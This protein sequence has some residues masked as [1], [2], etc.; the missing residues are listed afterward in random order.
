MHQI[1]AELCPFESFLQTFHSIL[2]RGNSVQI[3][4]YK[5]Y[6]FL[7]ITKVMAIRASYFFFFFFVLHLFLLDLQGNVAIIKLL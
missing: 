3:L 5:R 2:F 1:L 6:I 7:Q 4:F